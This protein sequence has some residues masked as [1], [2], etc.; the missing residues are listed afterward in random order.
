MQQQNPYN[1]QE[2]RYFYRKF[3]NLRLWQR[4]T[5]CYRP[6]YRTHRK[7][8]VS[9]AAIAARA[10]SKHN[11]LIAYSGKGIYRN[12]ADTV[13][14]VKLCLKLHKTLRMTPVIRG[15]TQYIPR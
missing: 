8:L 11:I 14:D 5:Q 9:Y 2:K 13:F 12:W 7:C 4:S 1:Y 10:N 6:I 15:I 3:Y